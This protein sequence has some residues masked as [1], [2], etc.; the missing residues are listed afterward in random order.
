MK[1]K[2]SFKT[3]LLKFLS[4]VS[5]WWG[6]A[7]TPTFF[8]MGVSEIA[9]G[10]S[11]IATWLSATIIA[12]VLPLVAGYVGRKRIKKLIELESIIDL[13]RIA[14][15]IAQA[16]RGILNI[17]LLSVRAEMSIEEAKAT[18]ENLVESGVLSPEINDE[19][20][21]IYICKDLINK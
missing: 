17:T 19:G 7:I 3:K 11:D 2:V 10:S 6:V 20:S 5:F 12:G 15:N 8:I 18:L 4:E 13:E 1:K 9:S 21:V 14:L 16:N